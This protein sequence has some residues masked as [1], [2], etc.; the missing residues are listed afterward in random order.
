[1]KQ[2]KILGFSLLVMAIGLACGNPAE[3]VEEAQE[4][5]EEMLQ[6]SQ[7]K[8]D[9]EF[10][11]EF[12][13]HLMMSKEMATI[14]VSKAKDNRVRKLA[15]DILSDHQKI[16]ARLDSSAQVV[17]MVL[18]KT[19]DEDEMEFISDFK[20]K[21]ASDFDEDYL[22]WIISTHEKFEEGAEEVI[23]DTNRTE[24][25]MDVARYIKS[26][27]FIHVNAAKEL[28]SEGNLTSTE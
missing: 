14:A 28:M 8:E 21:E 20:E 27:Q 2:I 6:S 18:P 11:T 24:S 17:G 12:A 1:M 9:A 16:A 26:Q 23:A 7:L 4:Q 15:N 25:L 13:Y 10:F 19:L 22:E 5:N 3:P